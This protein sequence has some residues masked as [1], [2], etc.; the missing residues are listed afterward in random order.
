[1]SIRSITAACALAGFSFSP[2]CHASVWINEIHYDNVGSDTGEFVEVAGAAGTDLTGWS[3]VLYNGGSGAPYRTTSL[4]VTLTNGTTNGFGFA[5]IDVGSMQNGAPDGLALTDAAGGVIQFLSYEGQFA[6]TSG[7][8]AGLTSVDIGVAELTS[9]AIGYSLQLAGSGRRYEDFAWLTEPLEHT[10]GIA[11]V[12]QTFSSLL[13]EDPGPDI[14]AVPAPG[15][16]PLVLGACA[17]F[18]FGDRRARPGT[19]AIAA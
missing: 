1:M 10:A 19:E 5:A 6:A 7:P 3:I 4:N 12:Q 8:A 2:L 16:L 14:S 15:V 11:N 13:P 9:T 17:W 18:A